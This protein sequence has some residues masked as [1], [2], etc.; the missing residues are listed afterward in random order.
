MVIRKKHISRRTVLRGA[1]V[2][3]ALPFLDAMVPAGTA[4]AK[5][6]A[7][8]LPRMGFFYFPHGAIMLKDDNRWSPKQTGTDF[9]IS[10]ILK[11]LDP[12]RSHMTIVSNLRNRPAES[13][14]PHGITP[15]TWLRCVAPG[16]T[17]GGTSADQLAAQHI[18]QST[19][20][21]SIEV[22]AEGHPGPSGKAGNMF[23][24][25]VSFR[26][27]TQALPMEY[28]PRKLFYSLFGKG[29]SPKERK[30]LISETSSI[31][32]FTLE[33]AA[34]FK[35]TLGA[36]DRAAVDNYLD[37]VREVERRVHKMA[38]HDLSGLNLPD[39]PL[40]VQDQFPA[41]QKMMFDLIALAYQGNLTRISTY[42][43]AAEAS[44]KA[45]TNLGIS[46][47]FHPLSHHGNKP[48]KLDRLQK[49]QAY[50]A[51]IFGD[52]LKQLAAMPDGDGTVL[53]N[54]I[55]LFGS[56]MSNSDLHNNDPLPSAIFG[57]GG[58]TIKG[59]QH[60]SYPHNTPHANL[61]LT[62][63]IRAGVPIEKFGD[64][65]GELTEI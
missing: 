41:Q 17:P 61:L 16:G 22:A 65:T 51:K 52:F 43:M 45:Y 50:H 8:P 40:G 59:G 21:P 35:T 64:S 31:L 44:M 56:N 42:M 2:S 24:N 23:G 58:G 53:D 11:P 34:S 55:L 20:F 4:L 39:P 13:P 29:D 48:D 26:T 3:I 37:S 15:G 30:E 49:I 57:K 5:T 28:D 27:P 6:A 47:A 46:E 62:M 18:G 19:P 25:T 60:L 32:D 7:K 14:D 38:S 1:G 36:A 9:E 63:L 54:S 33:R 10:P 12:F